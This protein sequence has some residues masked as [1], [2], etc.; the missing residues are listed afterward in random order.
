MELKKILY[1]FCKNNSLE[2]LTCIIHIALFNS[3][4]NLSKP[5]KDVNISPKVLDGYTGMGEEKALLLLTNFSENSE[6]VEK[7]YSFNC[8][9]NNEFSGS[10][11]EEDIEEEIDIECCSSCNK[12]HIF[13]LEDAVEI[14]FTVN[15][16]SFI[17]ELE[18]NNAEMVVF[19]TNE[20]HIDKLANILV[21]KL[22]LNQNSQEEVK[23][24]MIKYLHSIKK[25]SGLISN[26][27][28]DAAS[29]T[30]NVKQIVEDLS[31]FSSIK[32]LFS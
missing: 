9:E 6:I 32:D 20:E 30:G 29:T 10:V 12:E 2:D 18:I 5:Q 31:G 3:V 1:D 26:I 8:L 17:K 27:S 21:S 11:L 19:N 23:I 15:K 14:S 16:D 28:G 13:I 24:G 4:A 7:Y 25:F 22:T